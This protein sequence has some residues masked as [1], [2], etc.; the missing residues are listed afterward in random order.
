MTALPVRLGM[1]TGMTRDVSASGI[2]FETEASDSLGDMISFTVEF[3][4][5]GGKRMLRCQGDV[6]RIEPRNTGVGV[7]V[8]ITESRIELSVRARP[9]PLD[10]GSQKT[11]RDAEENTG[12]RAGQDGIVISS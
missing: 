4:T 7:A 10:A 9:G 8:K 6:V 3:D 11:R 2:F 5:P 12:R 1:A